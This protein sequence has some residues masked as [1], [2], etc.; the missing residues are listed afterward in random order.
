MLYCFSNCKYRVYLQFLQLARKDP[1]RMQKGPFFLLV[2]AAAVFLTGCGTIAFTGVRVGGAQATATS[3]QP[4]RVL[5]RQTPFDVLTGTLYGHGKTAVLLAGGASGDADW[6]G[7]AQT[8]SD[9]GFTALA[10][11]ASDEDTPSGGDIGVA[12]DFL[13]QNGFTAVVC[14]GAGSGAGGCAANASHLGVV[15]LVL[16]AYHGNVD[17]S[18]AGIPKLFV[19]AEQDTVDRPGT[20]QGYQAAAQPKALVIVPGSAAG[21]PSLLASPGAQDLQATLLDF[22]EQCAGR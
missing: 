9:G 4:G 15:G 5:I 18:R 8:L 2:F 20:E 1:H 14:I 7:L 13:R 17:L 21:G 10:L 22:V 19:A 16:F 11:T 3:L 12:I 6:S